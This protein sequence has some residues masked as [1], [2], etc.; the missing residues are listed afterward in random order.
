LTGDG[1]VPRLGR[2]TDG[3]GCCSDADSA[4]AE[5]A[6]TR[7]PTEFGF[8]E[9]WGFRPRQNADGRSQKSSARAVYPGSELPAPSSPS[10]SAGWRRPRT[11]ATASTFGIR[12]GYR[13]RSWAR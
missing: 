12:R 3:G 5:R 4:P 9:G 8:G 11:W 13:F 10:S 7:S 2:R 6:L 1:Q